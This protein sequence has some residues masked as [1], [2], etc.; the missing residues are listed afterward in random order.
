MKSVQLICITALALA[1][2]VFSVA[3]AAER[4]QEGFGQFA[5][6]ETFQ[7]NANSISSG[8]VV[9]SLG[10]G[11]TRTV[12]GHRIGHYKDGPVPLDLS[13]RVIAAYVP[14]G[15]GGYDEIVGTGTSAGT[16]T[17]PNVPSG[18][19]LLRLGQQFLWTKKTTIN[20]DYYQDFR[21]TAAQPVNDTTLTFDLANLNAW[22]DTDIFEISGRT[23]AFALFPGVAGETTF[24]GTFPYTTYLNDTT[25]GDKPYLLQLVT[26]PAGGYDFTAAAR[27]YAPRNFVQ[28][29]G[30]DTSVSGTLKTINQNQTFRANI[31]GADLA[32]QALAA[33]PGAVLVDTVLA[34]D[35]YPGSFAR[36]QV[37]ST[38][39]LVAYDLGTGMPPLTVNMDAGDL[40]YGNP[41]PSSWPLFMIYQYSAQTSYRAPGAWNST[42]LATGAYGYTTA[43]PTPTSPIQP[44]VGTVSR[45]SIEGSYF[46]ANQTGIGLTPTLS[47]SPPKVGTADA[48]AI[49]VY[50]LVN[51]A[52][53]TEYGQIA[54]LQTQRTSITIPPGLLSVGPNTGQGYVFKIQTIY[55]PG[56]DV[57]AKPYVSGPTNASADVIS[58]MMQ[59]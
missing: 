21:S 2:L 18:F 58:G 6:Q 29:D 55:R 41:F 13:I 5:T 53:N 4:P 27:Y 37:V 9:K 35:A 28:V 16:F 17:I 22:Q 46:F 38:P 49:F 15:T 54:R 3:M 42:S 36:G 51:N 33:N 1:G 39:D 45:P 8:A 25:Q 50:Q 43:L 14:N 12:S 11:P 30:A 20:A 32:A 10:S 48:Y 47:W 19:Y 24:T 40:F 57:A 52:G 23:P 7:N 59:P 26:Q 34:L 44:L 56:V 31:N